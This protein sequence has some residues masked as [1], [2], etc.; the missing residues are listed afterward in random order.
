MMALLR[1]FNSRFL[2]KN[3]ATIVLTLAGLNFIFYFFNNA[4]SFSFPFLAIIGYTTFAVVFGILVNEAVNNNKTV[5]LLF[6][7]S[8]MKFFGRISYGLYIFHWP[9]YLILLKLMS[10]FPN[11]ITSLI[12]TIIAIILSWLS[13]EFFEA[14]ILKLKK[15]FKYTTV[16]Y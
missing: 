15:N 8:I 4:Y 11:L 3:I 14:K 6:D 12:A 5:V 13:F 1:Q 9:I 2:Q 10:N 16:N 7:N